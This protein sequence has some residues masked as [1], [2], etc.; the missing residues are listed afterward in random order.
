M[1]Y[2]I[3]S[4]VK[5]MVQESHQELR[6]NQQWKRKDQRYVMKSVDAIWPHRVVTNDDLP[7]CTG[8]SQSRL[9]LLDLRLP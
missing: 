3:E 2:L 6:W 4:K 7:R 9:Q 8:G 5:L 1:T